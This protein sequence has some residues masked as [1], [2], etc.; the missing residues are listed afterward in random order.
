MGDHFIIFLPQFKSRLNKD[1]ELMIVSQKHRSQRMNLEDA[2]AKVGYVLSEASEVPKGPS[3]LTMARVKALYVT[4]SILL[5][6]VSTVTMRIPIAILYC[7]SLIVSTVTM[8]IP[9]A[10]LYC[11]SLIVSTVTMRIP[12]AI[13]YCMSLIVSTVTMRI[14]I[15]ILYC[16]SLIVST[17]TMRIPIAILYCMSLIVSTVTMR[18]P[19]YPLLYVTYSI[20]SYYEDT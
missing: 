5:N 4:Y 17:V 13:L 15:A 1:G 20:Y 7:M 19:S 16:M 11:M 8:R 18:I 9:I 10:I 2:I 12:I 6:V 14:P 3:H